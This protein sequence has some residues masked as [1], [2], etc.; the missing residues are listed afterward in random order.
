MSKAP[1]PT[2]L[3]RFAKVYPEAI[4]FH[5]LLETLSAIQRLSRGVDGEDDADGKL[6]L[7]RI[8]RGSALYAVVADSPDAATS[9]LRLT[10]RLLDDPQCADNIEHTINPIRELSAISK[11]MGTAIEI[12]NPQDQHDVIAKILP[13]SYDLISHSL[14]ASG[15]SAIRGIV[16]RVGGATRLHCGLRVPF[17]P[18]QLV[19]KVRN[20]D[21][22]RRLGQCLYRE[23]SVEGRAKWLKQNLKIV[24]FKIE[25]MRRMERT[26]IVDSFREIREATKSAWDRIDDPRAFLNETTGKS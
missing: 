6:S 4:P 17:Q 24:S 7:L 16:E 10:G 22:A 23:V 20:A 12:I 15:P 1:Q 13:E 5:D 2:F 3:I 18:R 25:S 14:L 19:C 11:R 9:Q 21:I 8:K 26:S